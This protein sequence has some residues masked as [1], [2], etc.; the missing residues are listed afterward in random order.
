MC[1]RE[2]CFLSYIRV[3]LSPRQLLYIQG[4]SPGMVISMLCCMQPCLGKVYA[5]TNYISL[6]PHLLTAAPSVIVPY[7]PDGKATLL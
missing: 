1:G 3:P 4:D 6:H 5:I 2:Q 7:Q